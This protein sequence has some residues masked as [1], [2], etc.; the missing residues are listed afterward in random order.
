MSDREQRP[1]FEDESLQD[2]RLGSTNNNGASAVES[3]ST[4]AAT[5]SP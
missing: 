4:F 5:I 2:A 3:P 1:K